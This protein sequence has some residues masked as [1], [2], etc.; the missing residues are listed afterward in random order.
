MSKR[1]HAIAL[2]DLA[3]TV[4]RAHGSETVGNKLRLLTCRFDD[5]HCAANAFAA[6]AI[7]HLSANEI[8]CRSPREAHAGVFA[9]RDGRL[10]RWAKS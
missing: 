9:L 8:S 10:G 3:L 5:A 7:G 1:E 6:T 2:R 4:A